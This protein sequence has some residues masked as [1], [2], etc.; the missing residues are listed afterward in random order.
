M[1]GLVTTAVAS[2]AGRAVD[3]VQVF[4]WTAPNSQSGHNIRSTGMD[5][6]AGPL[7][8]VGRLGSYVGA[9]F[10]PAAEVERD[11][12]KRHRT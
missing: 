6:P 5:L 4:S 3:L 8:V 7:L 11:T 2:L 12:A 10:L 9:S 1:Q